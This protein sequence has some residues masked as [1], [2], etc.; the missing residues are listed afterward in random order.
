MN[1]ELVEQGIVQ[2]SDNGFTEI[3]LVANENCEEC[4]AKLFCNT[5]KNSKNILII[6]TS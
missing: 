5:N 6:K 2:K 3:E 1:E 4:S